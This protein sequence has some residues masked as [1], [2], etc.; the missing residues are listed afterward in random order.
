M[1]RGQWTDIKQMTP[2]CISFADSWKKSAKEIVWPREVLTLLPV[3]P[4]TLSTRR[5]VDQQ[6]LVTLA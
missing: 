3:R 6:E 1:R 2:K 5:N 4:G